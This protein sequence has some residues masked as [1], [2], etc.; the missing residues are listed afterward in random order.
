MVG[1]ERPE[2]LR[3]LRDWLV[4]QLKALRP[5]QPFPHLPEDVP[6][7]GAPFFLD[8]LDLLALAGTA[9]DRFGVRE[10]GLED[11]FLA[12]RTLGEWAD[13]ILTS[14]DRTADPTVGF[15]TSGSTGQP[16][17]NRH[18]L[19]LLSEE[20]AAFAE[21]LPP[22]RRVLK[23]VPAH[24]IYG[25]L[26]TVLF[27]SHRSVPVVEVAPEAPVWDEGDLLVTHP[28]H[29][30]LWRLRGL[31]L[32]RGLVVLT[33]TSALDDESWD[34]LQSAG[35]RVFEV[36]GSS[37]T[38]GI[39]WRTANDEPFTLLPYWLWDAE[40]LSRPGRD[41]PL[42]APDTLKFVDDRRFWPGGRRDE[43]FKV[44]GRLVHLEVVRQVLQQHPLVRDCAVKGD[45]TPLGPRVKAFVVPQEGWT[46]PEPA[47]REWVATRLETNAQPY[48]YLFGPEIPPKIPGAPSW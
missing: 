14:W 42:P 15:L 4:D 12:R 16:Q 37:E 3:F 45:Q 23:S 33:S 20:I 39:G 5:G 30:K 40:G 8:S 17:E 24:H 26:F 9:A 44:A 13:L 46:D 18:L 7:E 36:F 19:R 32:P 22:V 41:S 34:W 48:R 25:F 28:L 27:P 29:L 6:L 35:S 47:L 11:Y 2:A 31:A 38:A 1:L 10:S 21:V 43:A